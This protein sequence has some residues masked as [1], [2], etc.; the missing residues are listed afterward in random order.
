MILLHHLIA[1]KGPHWEADENEEP[2]ELML[3][4]RNARHEWFKQVALADRKG[5]MEFQ[6]YMSN[7]EIEL[8]GSSQTTML[9]ITPTMCMSG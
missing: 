6:E 8:E 1:L 2:A 3:S 7:L 5:T 9:I 4:M